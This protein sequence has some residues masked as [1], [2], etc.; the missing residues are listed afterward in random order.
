MIS[1]WK[2]HIYGNYNETAT[3][4]L[5]AETG[6]DSAGDTIALSGIAADALDGSAGKRIE[7][8]T[9]AETTSPRFD[10]DQDSR[11]TVD[12]MAV[13][14]HTIRR[15]YPGAVKEIIDFTT[16]ADATWSDGTPVTPTGIFSGLLGEKRAYLDS[17]GVNDKVA[18]SDSA[19]LTFGDGATDKPCS[20]EWRGTLD[21]IADF[22]F[23]SKDTASNREWVFG[24]N[25]AGKPFLLLVDDSASANISTTGDDALVA[26]QEY[27]IVGTYDGAGVNSGLNLI[28]DGVLVASTDGGVGSYVAMENKTADM[29]MMFS[30]YSAYA[31]G[32]H[33]LARLWNR[34]LST[35]EALALFD[36]G[37]VGLTDQWPDN[38]TEH[39][40]NG[41]FATDTAGL[42]DSWTKGHGGNTASILNSGSSREQK[43]DSN[44]QAKAWL[45]QA[46]ADYSTVP[47]QGK[48]FRVTFDYECSTT[49][50][51]LEGSG[52]GTSI[53]TKAA[54]GSSDAAAMVSTSIEWEGDSSDGIEANLH[55]QAVGT[56]A[57]LV[58]DNVKLEQIGC[59]AEYASD[60]INEDAG[61][62]YDSSTNFLDGT[63]TGAD[64]KLNP[65]G[66]DQEFTLHEFASV[67]N[68]YLFFEF[69]PAGLTATA[70]QL[71]V[72][73]LM[74]GEKFTPLS[75]DLGGA[76]TPDRSGTVTY[77]SSGGNSSSQQR[78]K[79]LQRWAYSWTDLS[80]SRKA[81]WD[82]FLDGSKLHP[83]L[84]TPDNRITDG[85]QPVIYLVKILDYTFTPTSYGGWDLLLT[86]E[87][88]L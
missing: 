76:Q 59:V 15:S 17:D 58:V 35:A 33:G 60:G 75:A 2:S 29:S 73:E 4:E 72:G 36:G 39:I 82:D 79:D 7:I 77:R 53:G 16:E 31:K 80:E 50:D 8:D 30:G 25:S 3:P 43:V 56:S 22:Y 28:V 6:T 44:G 83:C 45:I 67:N 27:H 78:Y 69:N 1:F 46:A 66:T 87:E 71:L 26:G 70:N 48:R 9:N 49:L 62:W 54:T 13:L 85:R 88:V 63:I 64:Y 24:T 57:W 41:D 32:Q 18:V 23:V 68:Q 14:G 65:S 37:L 10:V 11:T 5:E 19:K 51:I 55:F 38:S 47:T 34:E 12:F 42:G 40:A 52:A 81:D 84:F 74:A 21:T 20:F 86:V 61:K